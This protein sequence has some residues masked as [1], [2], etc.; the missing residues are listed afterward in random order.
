MYWP[1]RNVARDGQH[2]GVVAI[3]LSKLVPCAESWL[4]T[5]GIVDSL[6]CASVWSSV[7][8][9]TM[10]GFAPRP[11]GR[12]PCPGLFG[13]SGLLGFA[14]AAPSRCADASMASSAKATNAIALTGK[15][16]LSLSVAILLL[17]MSAT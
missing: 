11:G 16:R 14:A 12:S 15:R 13:L 8:I 7:V 6:S 5:V 3:A 9:T 10:F 4:R 1:V 17:T 2:R